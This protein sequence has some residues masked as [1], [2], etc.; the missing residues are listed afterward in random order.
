MGQREAKGA[1][2][3]VMV[4]A[5]AQARSRKGAREDRQYRWEVGGRWR[6]VES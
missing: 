2:R 4:M 1:S 3:G 5:M 6:G